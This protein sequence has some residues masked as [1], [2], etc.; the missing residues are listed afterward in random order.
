MVHHAVTRHSTGKRF[1]PVLQE[2][3]AEVSEKEDSGTLTARAE[4]LSRGHETLEKIT[5]LFDYEIFA[6]VIKAG[7]LS[8]AARELHSSPAMISKRLTRLE[9][10]LG[11]RLLQRTTRRL[12]PTQVGQSFFERVVAVLAAVED[13]E[14][15]AAVDSERP[16]GVLKVSLPTAF[17]RL[18]VAPRLK[19]FLDA[20]TELKMVVDLSDD[21][22][23]LV[24]GSFDMA[25]R[26][27]TLPDSSLVARRLASNR[28]VFCASPLYLEKHGEPRDL[29][30]LQRHRLVAAGP[31]I[32]WRLEGP[33][34][35]VVLKP[36]TV[37][38]TNSSEVVREAVVSGLGIGFR[39]T[40]DVSAELKRGVLRRVLPA[41][42]SASD[43]NI[44]AVYSGR[45][46]V[47]VKVRAFVD[48]LVA[49]FGPEEPYWDREIQHILTRELGGEGHARTAR[50]TPST[51]TAG[52]TLER[53]VP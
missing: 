17:G 4:I 49:A 29:A 45:R 23:D 28:R 36:H 9:E 18:H 16:R 32:T 30:E 52:A 43:V 51:A 3:T 37:L 1:F 41:Y 53:R 22:V 21:Y 14:N 7:S 48:Y 5:N 11:V 42:G 25:V 38:E 13:A 24:A 20:N 27:G 33:E 6:R 40:W 46:L 19:A 47:P 15:F 44:Y 39:S 2:F 31:Q 35:P 12:T 26:I 8:A 50:Q 10:R 34:G